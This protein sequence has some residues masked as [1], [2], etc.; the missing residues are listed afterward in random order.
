MP[1]FE[2]LTKPVPYRRG[3]A[4]YHVGLIDE[5]H[6]GMDIGRGQNREDSQSRRLAEALARRCDW[7]LLLTATRHRGSD[8]FLASLW[9]LLDP[10][11]VDGRRSPR[12]ERY[13]R[14]VAR[15][16]KKPIRDPIDP[17]NGEDRFKE[18]IV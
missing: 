17:L 10:S 15:R 3:A 6:H 11:L 5:A 1:A 4:S 7:L 2:W 13:R 12:E 16:Q 18:G 14:H 8:R 9:E